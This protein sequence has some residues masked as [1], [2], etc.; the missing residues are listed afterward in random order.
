MVIQT[1]IKIREL[2]PIGIIERR[3]LTQKLVMSTGLMQTSNLS[4]EIAPFESKKNSGQ[5]VLQSP[6]GS[7]GSNGMQTTGSVRGES[8]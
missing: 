3:F 1:A 5:F 2:T 4:K 8:N 6:N 7:I